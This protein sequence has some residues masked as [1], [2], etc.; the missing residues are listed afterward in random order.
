MCVA[1]FN[2]WGVVPIFWTLP[3]DYL[4]ERT[5]AAGIAFVSS[6][7]GVGGFAGPYLVGLIKDST[8]KFQPAVLAMAVAILLQGC[9]VMAMK[10]DR[11][12]PQRERP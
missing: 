2:I 11:G 7:A 10:I 1:A 6:W 4:G 12:S 3:A 5:A 8:G 9:I